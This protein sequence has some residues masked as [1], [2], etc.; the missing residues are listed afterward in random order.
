MEGRQPGACTLI[1]TTHAPFSLA[2]SASFSSHTNTQTCI[3]V[4]L[5]RRAS[6]KRDGVMAG[7]TVPYVICIRLSNSNNSS[8]NG[9][10]GGSNGDPAAAAA[11][12]GDGGSTT[13]QQ[14]QGALKME[15]GVGTPVA[16]A[17]SSPQQQQQEG[18]NTAAATATGNSPAAAA[19]AAGGGGGGGVRAL[20]LAAAASK[21][22]SASGGIA[23]R[24]FHPDELRADPTLVIDAEYYLAQQVLPVVMRLCAP[25]EVG[26]SECV[27]GGG[28]R[29]QT[30]GFVKCRSG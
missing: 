24:A 15:E 10:D 13:P 22:G 6:G 9:S 5:R 25:I 12:T 2:Q 28:G 17:A 4:A 23:E 19:A 16:A 29:V 8:S 20:T 21:G 1:L 26:F 14:Q 30:L 3:Q 27:W 7:E 11:A 18:S